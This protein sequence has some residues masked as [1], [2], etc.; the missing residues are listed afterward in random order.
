MKNKSLLKHPYK[1]ATIGATFWGLTLFLATIIA[2]TTGYGAPFLSV[3]GGIYPG[4]S[5]SYSGS[6][7]V[8][9]F[10]FMDGFIICYLIAFFSSN[11][12]KEKR[13]K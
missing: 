13:K 5:I 2:I 4:F 3:V 8:L 1:F 6:F 7:N 10:G 12:R 11:N 9:F